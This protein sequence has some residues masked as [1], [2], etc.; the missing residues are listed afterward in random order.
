MSRVGHLPVEIPEKVE[1]TVKDSV[2]KVKGPKGELSHKVN[3]RLDIK[4][5]DNTL[6]I[7]RSTDSRDD[8]AT[9]GLSRS[10]IINMIEGVTK[11][12]K[13]ELE[14]NGVG[15]RA[16]KQGNN[17]ELQVGYS[18]P[19]V[20]E[21]GEGIELDVEGNDKIIVSGTDKQK[22]GEVAANIRSVR[23]PE[24]YNGKGIKYVDEYIRR[25][26]GKTG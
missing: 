23:E 7:T 15:Y 1:V 5:E 4:I 24:P 21:P 10:L 13:K 3:D 25:K 18:H 6:V 16:K 20:I 19:V 12:F 8:K 2:V 9:H 11:G 26:E 14:L 22:V 17:L